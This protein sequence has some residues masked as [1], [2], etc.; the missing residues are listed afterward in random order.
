M[1]RITTILERLT[2]QKRDAEKLGELRLNYVRSIRS[3]DCI[4]IDL[5]VA[6]K[7]LLEILLH[8]LMIHASMLSLP[9]VRML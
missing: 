5:H 1:N 7:K 8:R 3:N 2:E 4:T 6:N 9:D